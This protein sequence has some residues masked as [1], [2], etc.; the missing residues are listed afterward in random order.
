MEEVARLSEREQIQTPREKAELSIDW[1]ITHILNP[2]GDTEQEKEF[3]K[4]AH[5]I[6]VSCALREPGV[7]ET[8]K[9][10]EKIYLKTLGVTIDEQSQVEQ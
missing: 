3:M 1:A 9:E 8:L 2:C 6:A 4:Q 5:I 10:N 7:K